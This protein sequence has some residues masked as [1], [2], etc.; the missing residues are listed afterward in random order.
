VKCTCNQNRS[1][2][3]IVKI[4]QQNNFEGRGHLWCMRTGAY[5]NGKTQE[6]EGYFPF[7]Q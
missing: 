7:Q 3:G 1:V 4:L 5:E 6:K 2:K